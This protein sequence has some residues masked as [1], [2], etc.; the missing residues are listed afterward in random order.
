M[1]KLLNF[2]AALLLQASLLAQPVAPAFSAG[3]RAP[4]TAPAAPSL[5]GQYSFK[6]SGNTTGSGFLQDYIQVP[7]ASNLNSF[8]YG[9]TLE[10]WVRRDN[11][12][13]YESI[14]CNGWMQSY[15]LSFAGA[16]V[17]LQTN[18]GASF[19]D[20]ASDVLAGAWTHIAATYDG[21]YQ[22][23]Y[24]NGRLDVSRYYP[25][26]V[27]AASSTPLGIGADLVNDFNQNY[28]Q[29][30]IDEARVWNYARS[31]SQIQNS[32]LVSYDGSMLGLVGNWQLNGNGLDLS[33]GNNGTVVN[34]VWSLDGA[35]PHDLTIP[36]VSVT[37][38]L[39]DGLCNTS[40]EYANAAQV[41]VSWNAPLTTAY[42][43]HNG[44]DLW[45]C[46]DHATPAGHSGLNWL[47]VYLD[48]GWGRDKFAQPDDL[49]LEMFNDNTFHHREGDGQGGFVNSS[50]PDGQWNGRYTA[51]SGLPTWYVTEF[52][53]SLNLIGPPGTTF[54]LQLAQNW[55]N[56]PG[57]N[58][59]WPALAAWNS[60]ATWAT[61]TLAGQGSPYSFSGSVKY[62][63]RNPKAAPTAVA[64]LRVNLVADDGSGGWVIADTTLSKLDGSF[65]LSANHSYTRH[66]LEIDPLSLPRGYTPYS[67][68]ASQTGAGQ[69]PRV[70]D[71]QYAGSGAY[72]GAEF[73]LQDAL[74]L[75]VNRGMGPYFIIIAPSVVID[76]GA[77]NDF[78]IYKRHLGF[79]V[80]IKSLEDIAAG[81]GGLDLPE[82]IRNFE[83]DRRNTYGSRFRYL[84]LVGPDKIIPFARMSPE[85][86]TDPTL[87]PDPASQCRAEKGGWIT[88]WYYADLVSNWDSN[89]NGCLGDGTF[90]D[91]S[92]QQKTGY[93]PDRFLQFQPTVSVGRLPLRTPKEIRDALRQSML[94]EQ[95]TPDFKRQALLGMSMFSV[96]GNCWFPPDDAGGQY[97]SG[98]EFKINN[99]TY[100]CS[101]ISPSGQ[102]GSYVGQNLRTQLLGPTGLSADYFYENTPPVA[103]GSPYQSAQIVS[104]N[105]LTT[106]V[107]ADDYGLVFLEGHGNSNG[108][109]R[110]NW[111]GDSN[112]D[113]MLNN[114]TRPFG[115]PAKSAWEMGGGNLFTN[116]GLANTSTPAGRGAIWMVIACS[117]GL[118]ESE[119]NFGTQLLRSNAG[120]AWVGGVGTVP[121]TAA[122][123]VTQLIA[124]RLLGFE[125]RLGE[126]VWDGLGSYMQNIYTGSSRWHA[127]WWVFVTDLFGDP[128]LSYWGN[129]GGDANQSPWPMLRQTAFGEGFSRLAGA[130]QPVP[131]WTYAALPNV[132]DSVQPAP[133]VL[134]DN[135]VVVAHGVYVDI[136]TDGQLY[137]RLGGFQVL[138]GTP[139]ISTDRT[140]Y[141][142][143]RNGLLYALV[144]H[145]VSGYWGLRWQLD[146][147][148]NV[149][150][151]PIIG[152]DGYVAIAVDDGGNT[153]VLLVRPDGRIAHRT[154]DLIIGYITPFV[155]P[156]HAVEALA[157]DANRIIYLTTS[158]GAMWRLNLYCHTSFAALCM[159][160]DPSPGAAYTTAPLLAY[161]GVYAGRADGSL[162]RKDPNSLAQV[163]ATS[164]GGV[165]VAG[166]I[167]GPGWQ[168]LV[169]ADDN[170]LYSLTSALAPRWQ[171]AIPSG[172]R[173]QPAYTTDS[174]LVVN[175]SFLDVRDPH[176]GQL[177]SFAFLG[178]SPNG[179]A[180]AVG[181]GRQAFVQTGA[182]PVV[183]VGEGWA[184]PPE[185]LLAMPV[186]FT[187]IGGLPSK[188]IRLN[189]KLADTGAP[190][191]VAFNPTGLL[192]QRSLEDG[193]WED[194]AVLP[195]GTLTYTD[196]T[197]LDG[198]WYGYRLQVLEGGGADSDIAVLGA[199]VRSLPAEPV[200]PALTEVAAEGIDRL[201]VAWGAPAGGEVTHY[202]LERG[203]AAA[204]P[205]TAVADVPGPA[206]DWVDGGLT[207]D[208]D[209]FYRLVALNDAGESAPSNI[210]DGH[211][212]RQTLVA[213]QH[214]AARLLADGRIEV[215]WD[216]SPP[217]ATAMVEGRPEAVAGYT[218][219]GTTSS[220]GPFAFLPT[221]VIAIAFRVKFVQGDEESAYGES[222]LSIK[223]QSDVRPMFL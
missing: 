139:A 217:S 83:I 163:G 74:P 214:V 121:T 181:Y 61:A 211:T 43:L 65:S 56:G 152:S 137:Q 195:Y 128:T 178:A 204:G 80:E 207:A 51:N 97:Y 29:G 136:L 48:R 69:D 119:A 202:R 146:L 157:V 185:D 164:L 161:G 155:I 105:V 206:L 118:W 141:V 64:G 67:S 68:Y 22:K 143:S 44:T 86:I 138:R 107:Q 197:P 120:T 199:S 215:T 62:Q 45:V 172:F 6:L 89:N 190:P 60:P 201:R 133:V 135:T 100:T 41:A 93:T 25:G 130:Q 159:T 162:V 150:T 94:F 76:S 104:E 144:R 1:R 7:Y 209:Y 221:Q 192:L 39:N 87:R 142:A 85:A 37:P 101:N 166:P 129:P 8:P 140:I 187:A 79:D 82:K 81:Y 35:L 153:D 167:A 122:E 98:G 75:P 156:G 223:I 49:S 213:P 188:G 171:A 40:T 33:G 182:G 84:M 19:V 145:P 5:V 134:P 9:I 111:A 194:V 63:P 42:L 38:S 3:P 55:V 28:F 71:Y 220:T 99:K 115:N 31:A 132:L 47:A 212:R 59:I 203:P 14:I 179:G 175:G 78:A 117:T 103:G 210:L 160:V 110:T 13:R 208:T 183:A 216:G 196:T 200:A 170:N 184:L 90:G 95:Q 57:D 125:M 27:G 191:G 26:S 24:I 177:R 66:R 154:S 222:V 174:L 124:H 113:G 114:P 219:L 36:N 34:G 12:A 148:S 169:G 32:F 4:A 20:S 30:H 176:T 72:T 16:K 189:W 180:V 168:V 52:Q 21:Q 106:Y 88:D 10:A 198:Q 165:A 149:L 158:A 109:Y 73:R 173:G 50:T 147:G 193:D 23:I 58:R 70:I 102:D 18:G 91:P 116:G 15:C 46:F 218:M 151:S 11:A 131:L 96:K 92:E 17:R 186:Q 112:G 77:L 53:I 127:P 54:G 2:L 123:Q 126:A 205:F 108:V